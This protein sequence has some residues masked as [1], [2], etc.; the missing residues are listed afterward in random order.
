[1]SLT[2]EPAGPLRQL[3]A[4]QGLP[5]VLA[6]LAQCE[7]SLA[8][9][10]HRPAAE[11]SAIQAA[12]AAAGL[13]CVA[14]G[15]GESLVLVPARGEVWL[16]T[17]RIAELRRARIQFRLLWTIAER[18]EQLDRQGLYERVWELPYRSGSCDNALYVSATRLRARLA[19]TGLVLAPCAHGGYRL[20]DGPA[21]WLFRPGQA[22]PAL[23]ELP[24]APVA[25]P[26]DLGPVSGDFVGRQGDMSALDE[27]LAAGQRLVTLVG[28][29]VPLRKPPAQLPGASSGTGDGHR[30]RDRRPVFPRLMQTREY[31]GPQPAG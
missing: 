19:S 17:T 29:R 7:R 11:R 2:P 12:L 21:V 31:R 22:P 6:A 20:A 25:E 18:G 14:P 9:L 8:Q 13:R 10:P 24:A 5:Q 27:A 30:H 4:A 23:P 1:M 15:R 26:V 16:G 3:Q 28:E